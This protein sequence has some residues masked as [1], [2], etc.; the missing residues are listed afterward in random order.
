[1]VFWLVVGCKGGQQSI[2]TTEDTAVPEPVYID[3]DT[4]DISNLALSELEV[5]EGVTRT[6]AMAIE[7]NTELLWSTYESVLDA[8]AGGC[9]EY[10]YNTQYSY[11][12]EHSW[13]DSCTTAGGT[14]YSGSSLGL[15]YGPHTNGLLTYDFRLSLSSSFTVT[16]PDGSEFLMSGEASAA[17]FSSQSTQTSS[18]SLNGEF[19]SN[20]A[21]V[22]GTWLD[23]NLLMELTMNATDG[24]NTRKVIMEGALVGMSGNVTASSYEE[25]YFQAG[26]DIACPIEPYGIISVRDEL[27][28]WYDVQFHGESP[29]G[30][31]N[32]DL[33]DG[34]GD[35]LYRGVSIGTACPNLDPYLHWTGSPW[36]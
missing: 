13:A 6:L 7:M 21:D 27:G 32:P 1:M 33:C 20:S 35:I 16:W 14:T 11:G 5:E 22:T 3:P 8:G 24:Y 28:D 15:S 30:E 25:L 36:D 17:R 19:H 31:L 18:S 34:C 12:S 2:G 10:A 4:L 9:P 23:Q 29:S 26:T